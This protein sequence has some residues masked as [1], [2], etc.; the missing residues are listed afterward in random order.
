MKADAKVRK[1][2][3]AKK[4]SGKKA[5]ALVEKPETHVMRTVRLVVGWFFLAAGLYLLVA[6]TSF[7]FTWKVDQSVALSDSL[8]SNTTEAVNGAGKIGLYWSNL[9]IG[10]LFGIGAFIIPFF[11]IAL[12]IYCLSVRKMRIF[13]LFFMAAFGCVILSITCGYIFS[14]TKWEFLFGSGIGGTYGYQVNEWLMKMLGSVG[15]GVVLFFVLTVWL[16]PLIYGRIRRRML[17]KAEAASEADQA[18]SAEGTEDASTATDSTPTDSTDGP[19]SGDPASGTTGADDNPDLVT[20]PSVDEPTGDSDVSTGADPGGATPT[21]GAIKV[22]GT[23]QEPTDGINELYNPRLDLPR[24]IAPSFDLL[25][26]YKDKLIEVSQEELER[27]NYK[28]RKCLNTF[29]ISIEDIRAVPGPTVT[30]YKIVLSPGVRIQQFTRLENDI[31]LSLAALGMRVIAPIPGTSMVGIEVANDKPSLVPMKSVLESTKFK[32]SKEDLPIVLGKSISNEIILL[33]LAKMPHLLVAGA[34]GQG[35][36]VALNAI[37]ASLLYK[38]HPAYMKL[39]L[40]DPKRVE[41][42]LYAKLEKHFLAKLPDEEKSIITD[43][44]KVP[45]TLKSICIEMDDRLDMFNKAGVRNIKE[46]NAKFLSRHLNPNNGH[47]FMPFLVVI[48]DEF[49]DLIMISGRD[50]EGPLTRLAQMGRAAGIHLVIATQRPTTNIITG[51]IKANF[52][53]RIAFRV[54]SQTDSRTIIDVAEAK[55]LVGRGDMLIATGNDLI[56]AQCAFIDTP[57]VERLVTFIGDQPGYP[58]AFELPEYVDPNSEGGGF[59]H[60]DGPR[61]ELFAEAARMIVQVQYGSTSMLQRKMNLGYNRA[62]RLMDQLEQAGIVS[63][64]EGAKPRQ[65]L[66]GSMDSLEDLLRNL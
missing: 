8:F 2:K 49:A 22:E 62:A 56:R 44:K 12:A 13:P 1:P 48:I 19:L 15:T 37:I 57:E 16:V 43:A 42:S 28:I 17:R 18:T 59:D 26:D 5:A 6:F 65:V 4:A 58:G 46:Y 7:I 36:S 50:V 23:V 54:A 41:L 53:A 9:L 27:N 24:Y 45:P 35:K 61:D 34:T 29:N 30:L 21:S 51:T 60:A 39:V 11:F 63:P 31:M 3:S 10:R 14:F 66:V 25:N 20:G 40:V 47:R 52:P 55:Q 32:E 38:M 33:D 64:G